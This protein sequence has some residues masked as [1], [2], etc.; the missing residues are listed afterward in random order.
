MRFLLFVPGSDHK[1]TPQEVLAS[2][3]LGEIAHGVDTRPVNAGPNE[4]GGGLLFGWLSATQS[5]FDVFP[6][7][8]KWLPSLADGDRKSGAYWVG[9]WN[10]DPPTENDLRRPD[11][12]RG[13]QILLGND[14]SWS[15]PTPDT[16]DRYPQ[17]NP[18]NDGI[19]WMVDEQFNWLTTDLDKR[20]A[21]GVVTGEQE[22]KKTQTFIFDDET[23]FLFLCRLLQV[24][25]RITP[26]VVMHLR[27]WSE[28]AIRRTV[29]G[30]FGMSLTTEL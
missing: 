4:T 18:D 26:E 24:N 1:G 16:L 22:G 30:L 10:N 9:L 17:P 13:R 21:T 8:Q 3:G 19:V 27:L 28:D 15:I 11:H 25:Y 5:Q 23:D 6:E 20:R 14:E 2:V 7:R 29:A 12:R